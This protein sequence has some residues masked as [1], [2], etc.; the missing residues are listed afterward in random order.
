VDE[1]KV[2]TIYGKQIEISTDDIIGCMVRYGSEM[3]HVTKLFDESGNDLSR[4]REW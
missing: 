1:M 4:F 2:K 3:Y